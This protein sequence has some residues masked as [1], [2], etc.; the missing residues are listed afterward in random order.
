MNVVML[1]VQ[2]KKQQ[3]IYNERQLNYNGFSDG[4]IPTS[5]FTSSFILHASNFVWR[6]AMLWDELPTPRIFRRCVQR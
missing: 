4:S 1:F 2:P 6:H 3:M 5:Y